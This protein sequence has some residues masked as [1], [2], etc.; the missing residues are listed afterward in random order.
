MLPNGGD[1]E[2]QDDAPRGQKQQQHPHGR[3]TVGRHGAGAAP[4]AAEG[5][6]EAVEATSAAE[7]RPHGSAGGGAPR[8]VRPRKSMREAMETK[9]VCAQRSC[10]AW[11]RARS[12][13]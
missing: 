1:T 8:A 12:N 11:R 9:Q 10:S 4:G 7:G 5:G 13:V 6:E 3:A 2:G